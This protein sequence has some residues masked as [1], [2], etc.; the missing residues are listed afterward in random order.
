MQT[1]PYY[2]IQFSFRK[3]QHEKIKVIKCQKCQNEEGNV[4]CFTEKV[5]FCKKCDYEHHKDKISSKH[6]RKIIKDDPI[7][8]FGF[9][10]SHRQ[11]K[12]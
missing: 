12:N 9:C 10:N 8:D 11:N 3:D 5:Y 4:Y 1:L 6:D 2:L 7:L